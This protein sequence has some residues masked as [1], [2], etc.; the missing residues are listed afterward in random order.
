MSLFSMFRRRGWRSALALVLAMVVVDLNVERIGDRLQI[1][2]P[3]AGLACAIGTGNTV[4]Y[5]GRYLGLEMMIKGPKALLGALEINHRPDGC[6]SGF[7]SGHTA[8]ATFGAAG[9]AKT[10]LAQSKQGQIVV[11]LA[12]AYVGGS[13]VESDKH[14]LFQ[15]IAG[16]L[17]GLAMQLMALSWL[18]RISIAT[19]KRIRRGWMWWKAKIMAFQN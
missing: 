10:C 2:L 1:A 12:A 9:L 11:Y 17:L 19:A 13:R 8:V 14:Y 6:L 5:I 16:A 4:P 15:T 18:D 3:I 7:P